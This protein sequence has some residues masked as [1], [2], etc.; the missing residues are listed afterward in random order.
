MSKLYKLGKAIM[1]AYLCRNSKKN[2]KRTNLN[3][4]GTGMINLGEED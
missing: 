3:K 4:R 2:K 1:L